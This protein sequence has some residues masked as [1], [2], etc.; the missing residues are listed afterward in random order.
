MLFRRQTA[1]FGSTTSSM[2]TSFI[3]DATANQRNTS[4]W[5]G[6]AEGWENSNYESDPAI[7]S[8]NLRSEPERVGDMEDDS[9]LGGCFP[10]TEYIYLMESANDPR[11]W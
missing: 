6:F 2:Q 5:D 3:E 1:D 11:C 7:L 4:A 8:H 10:T 9:G